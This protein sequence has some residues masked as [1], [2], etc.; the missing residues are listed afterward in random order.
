VWA[1]GPGRSQDVELPAPISLSWTIQGKA[2]F[3]GDGKTEFCGAV[4]RRGHVIWLM[5]GATTVATGYTAAQRTHVGV[6][7]G[8]F[9]GDGNRTSCGATGEPCTSG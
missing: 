8:D 6:K 7:G 3:D 5:N 9:D 1:D 4:L 2:D